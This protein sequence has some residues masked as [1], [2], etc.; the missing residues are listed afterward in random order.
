MAYLLYAIAAMLLVRPALIDSVSF[1]LSA[2]ATAG[3]ILL[4]S[5]LRDAAGRLLRLRDRGLAFALV[6]VWATSLAALTFVLPVQVAVFE[7]LP[8]TAIPENVLA[9]P[10]YP[11]ILIVGALATVAGGIDAVADLLW[12]AGAVLP[13]LFVLLVC[14]LGNIE[15]ARL[16]VPEPV[17]LGA[18]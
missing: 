8:L 14:A 12:I 3:V 17:A 6:E 1:Q 2:T 18:A 5:P 9:A 7:S 11:A 15:A 10:L 4:A 13:R 16:A